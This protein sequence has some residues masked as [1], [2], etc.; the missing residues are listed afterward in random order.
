M[1]WTGA[2]SLREQKVQAMKPLRTIAIGGVHST[3]VEGVGNSSNLRRRENWGRRGEH[4]SDERRRTHCE[5][6]TARES[7]GGENDH[8]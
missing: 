1:E 4:E 6:D 7:R 5:A 8:K 3:V 2:R